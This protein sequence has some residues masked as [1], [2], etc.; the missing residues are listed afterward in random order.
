MRALDGTSLLAD[1]GVLERLFV[2]DGVDAY[3][4]VILLGVALYYG[5][6]YVADVLARAK[7]QD[8]ANAQAK[9][10]GRADLTA[11]FK[12]AAKDKQGN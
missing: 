5:T 4:G 7:A 11:A 2:R 12:K 10:D 1:K 9:K 6:S 3:Y 8:E